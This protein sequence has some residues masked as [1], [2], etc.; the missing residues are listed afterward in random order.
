MLFTG[1]IPF[2]E[3][4]RKR[5]KDRGV[6]YCLWSGLYALFD[7]KKESIVMVVFFNKTKLFVFV[8]NSILR[9]VFSFEIIVGF[10]ASFQR[11]EETEKGILFIQILFHFFFVLLVA[12]LLETNVYNRRT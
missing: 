10:I 6:A 2:I 7:E 9:E 4:I 12:V 8:I 5:I 3:A 1:E 11:V